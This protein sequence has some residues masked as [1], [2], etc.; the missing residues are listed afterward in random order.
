ML[1]PRATGLHAECCDIDEARDSKTPV[2]GHRA[3]SGLNRIAATIRPSWVACAWLRARSRSWR[4]TSGPP[5]A[6]LEN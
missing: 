3:V 1:R 6:T 2:L 4:L 5:R